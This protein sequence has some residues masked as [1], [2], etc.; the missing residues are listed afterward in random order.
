MSTEWLTNRKALI[1]ALLPAIIVL[2]ILCYFYLGA[3]KGDTFFRFLLY[4]TPGNAILVLTMVSYTYYVTKNAISP[5]LCEAL[6]PSSSLIEELHNVLFLVSLALVFYPVAS[7]LSVVFQEYATLASASLSLII[8][9]L[10]LV[11]FLKKRNRLL[12]AFSYLSVGVLIVVT[13]SLVNTV[14]DAFAELAKLISNMEMLAR[15][16]GV[17]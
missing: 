2:F 9:L 1:V 11:L 17:T 3:L 5:A 13:L 7:S 6:V 10:I 12:I 16:L 15:Q 4:T 8:S 14:S